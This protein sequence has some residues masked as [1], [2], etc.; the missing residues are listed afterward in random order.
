MLDSH[1]QPRSRRRDQQ[2]RS[3]SIAAAQA[4]QPSSGK[5]R[6][7]RRSSCFE[8]T[9][10]G[11]LSC[12]W[13]ANGS[14][15]EDQFEQLAFLFC[16]ESATVARREY[17]SGMAPQRTRRTRFA[18]FVQRWSVHRHLVGEGGLE[19]RMFKTPRASSSKRARE[20]SARKL[21]IASATEF[22][23]RLRW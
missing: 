17:R 1:I 2:E 19:F 9:A 5:V 22:D 11:C 12:C 8:V 6:G 16:P 15:S 14:G 4:N 23:A 7:A 21:S 10:Y 3:I 20:C 13:D 18:I